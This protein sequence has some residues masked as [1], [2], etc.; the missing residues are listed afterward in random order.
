MMIAVGK[1]SDNNKKEIM[2]YIPYVM[3]AEVLS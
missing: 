1:R 3:V 2:K